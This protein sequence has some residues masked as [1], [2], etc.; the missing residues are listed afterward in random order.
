EI[1]VGGRA[2]A[3]GIFSEENFVQIELE[4]LIF[5]ESAVDA[6]RKNGFANF[7]RI[8]DFARE[9]KVSRHLLGY[10][11]GALRPAGRIQEIVQFGPDHSEDVDARMAVE[12]LVLGREKRL[13]D[14]RRYERDRNED[15]LLAGIFTDQGSVAGVNARR[16]RRLVMFERGVARKIAREP[17]NE[18]G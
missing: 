16:H 3:V 11:R 17:E 7:A 14:E 18:D 8:G 6:H 2:H 13:F 9:K 1:T 10:R 15:A 5:G 12:I 4:D